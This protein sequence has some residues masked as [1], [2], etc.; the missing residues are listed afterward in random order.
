MNIIAYSKALYT[1][2]IYY[3]PERILFDAGEGV[4][5]LLNNKVYAI[6]HIFLTHGHVD[7]ISGL[8]S[9]VNTRNNAMGDREKDLNIYY[10]KNNKGIEEYLKFIRKM[11]SE[12]RFKINVFPVEHGDIVYLREKNTQKYI[13]VFNVT[14]T[15]S[16]KSVGYHLYEVRKRLKK[17][18]HNLE[19]K[20]ISQLARKYGSEYISERFD[21][22]ILTVS[23]DTY[24]LKKEDVIDTEILFHE[25][26]FLKREDRK[27]KNH[28]VLEDIV[29]LIQGT[30]VKT[31]ILYHISGRYGRRPERFLEDYKDKLKGINVYM[32]KPDKIFKL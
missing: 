7:H 30:Q 8:W 10:P 12:L 5:A 26:T 21:K 20:E 27:Y 23:G 1:T 9:L 2:W 16:E 15:Y 14:H 17:E 25:C 6:K 11:N 13:K 4:S 28:A 3:S 22:K 18:F 24:L 31:L 19:Q 32:V 29:D